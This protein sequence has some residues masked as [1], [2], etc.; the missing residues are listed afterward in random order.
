[1][2]V[3]SEMHGSR[4]NG[5][6][7]G[8][9]VLGF[10]EIDQTQVAIVGGKGANLGELSHVSG[11]R[12]PAGFCVTTDAFQRALEQLPSID[13]LDELSG[14]DPGQ[15]EAVRSLSREIRSDLERTAIPDDVESAIVSALADMG[16]ESA[17]A[18]RSSTPRED[19]ATTSFAGL[20]D[21]YLDIVGPEA[22]L[23]HIR[24]CWASTFTERAVTYRLRRGPDGQRVG[25]AV[26]VQRMVEAHASGVLFT[27]DPVNGNRKVVTLEAIPGLGEPLVSGRVSPDAFRVRDGQIIERAVRS[28]LLTDAQVLELERLGRRVESHF[29]QPQDVEWCFDG[30]FRIVQSRPITTLFPLPAADDDSPR[31]YLSV[32]HQQMMTDPMK[33]LGMSFWQL[34]AAAPMHPAGGRL[35][36]DAGHLLASPTNRDRLVAGFEKSDPLT[37]D[38]LRTL[39][40]RDFIPLVAEDSPPPQFLAPPDPIETDQAIVEEL[41][42]AGRA[43][44][45]ALRHEIEQQT[46]SALIDAI[47]EDIPKMKQVLFDPRSYQVFMLAMNAAEWLNEHLEEWLGEKNLADT[48]TR[49]VPNNVTSEMGLALLDV[50]D[51]L[52]PHPDVIEFLRPVDHRDFLDELTSLDGGPQ[53]Q[54]ALQ[55]YLEKYG[56]R[57][58]GEIDI[59]RPRWSEEPSAL[60]PVILANIDNF[61]A[62]EASRRWQVGLVEAEAKERE[63]LERLRALPAGSNKADETKEMIDRVRTFI[64]YREYPKYG[65]VSRY[66]VYK[67]AL[68]GE[69]ARLARIGVLPDTED[70]FFL[71]FPELADAVRTLQVDTELIRERQ[72]AF[73]SYQTLT[74]PRV[75]T[76]EGEA[77]T[78]SY[79][80]EHMPAGTLVGVP[81]SAGT[82]EGRA[83]VI[84]DLGQA[85]LGTGDILVTAFTDPSWS[86]LFVTIKGLVTEVGGLMTHGAVIAREYGLPAVVGVERATQLIRDGQRIRIHGTDGF[87]ELLAD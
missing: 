56:M 48:L 54:R 28:H 65:M 39:I 81:V 33:P 6:R 44:V 3:V 19:S 72:R 52:R 66:S 1:M 57:C 32:G 77:V 17:Y 58:V 26:V 34:T 4:S 69:A 22:I 84:A 63:V 41:I 27:A 82:V 16:S 43:S 49:S 2:G 35:F 13:R 86:P 36:V 20:H 21:T 71:T 75:L 60:V 62:G 25:M 74:P 12:V 76:S 47:V 80:R 30:H 50:A 68:L 24:R 42:A 8:R 29:G 40:A 83:R 46:G 55:A 7:T 61:E 9:Y 18:V 45:D 15:Q 31:V 53:V 64:G 23:A 87:V 79:R 78:G 73:V 70:A 67:Q 5:E 38:A 11:L 37:G 14:L 85:D 10:P 51:V 59:T